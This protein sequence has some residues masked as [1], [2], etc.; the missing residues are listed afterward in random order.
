MCNIIVITNASKIKDMDWFS[1]AM[2]A[3][4]RNQRDG[5]GFAAM[6]ETGNIYG[7]KTLL[8]FAYAKN[9]R[10]KQAFLKEYTEH[11]GTPS[12]V[13][14][15]AMFHGRTST[16]EGG[17]INT[18]PMIIDDNYLIHNG[19]VDNIGKEYKKLT[20]NDSEDILYHY[21]DGGMENVAK[22]VMGYYACALIDADKRLTIF[23]DSI[24][25]L[26]CAWSDSLDSHVFASTQA[27]LNEIAGVLK[28]TLQ[29]VPVKNNTHVVFDGNDPAD[30]SSFIPTDRMSY[31]TRQ[32]AQASIGIQLPIVYGKQD[33][34]EERQELADLVDD[35]Y[36]NCLN[37]VDDM[38]T[39]IDSSGDIIT[40]SKFKQMK[41]SDKINC[42]L[43]T[44]SG[45][46]IDPWGITMDDVNSAANS[47]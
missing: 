33:D 26:L 25:P 44:P 45:D 18:H 42:I 31:R 2:A 39:V 34:S 46:V 15:F 21:L 17:L 23:K 10:K 1:R 22:S 36:L 30:V 12:P 37:N 38:W 9:K 29:G 5:F 24:A 41:L 7:A 16:N 6:G 8:P 27:V 19:V 32:N 11:F 47:K 14:K 40:A 13:Y 28:E 43:K 4:L 35:Q 3:V 20:E